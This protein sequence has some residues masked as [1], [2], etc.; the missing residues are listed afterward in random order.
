[1][2]RVLLAVYTNGHFTELLR[3]ARLLMR[4]PGH[5]PTVY[6]ARAYPQKDRDVAACRAEGIM[7][8]DPLPETPDGDHAG[9]V[10][11][12]AVP[13][14]AAR[15]TRAVRAGLSSLPFPFTAVRAAARQAQQ[16]LAARRVVAGQEPA[17]IFLAEDGVGYET[18]TLIKAGHDR[19]VPSI[20]VPFTVANALEPAEAYFR[21]PAFNVNRFSNRLAAALHPNWV[22]EHRGQKLVRLPAPQLLAKEWWGLAP[23]LPWILH[24]GSADAI[25]VES[26]FMKDYY[27]REGLP[28][29]QLVETGALSDDALAETQKEAGRRR[30]E[31][32]AELGLPHDR[33]LLLC[34]LPPDQ[35]SI[36]GP[37]A[38]FDDY[39]TMVRAWVESMTAMPGWTVVVRL[40]PRMAYDEF[41]Y[42]EE[43]GVR[44]SQRDTATLIPL[45][46]L[47][48]AS[49]SA[50]IR[51]AIAC[52]KPVVNFD[53]YRLKWTD[54]DDALG[55]IRLEDKA[56]FAA[57][58]LRLASDAAYFE[59]VR[60][61]QQ[62]DA[63]RWA[64][65]DGRAAERL[66]QLMASVIEQ[67]PRPSLS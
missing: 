21:D 40:H 22:F 13:P 67:A 41:R 2:R 30:A 47:Y 9:L 63:P 31:L 29:R 35:F 8:V 14:P 66:L 24:S 51:W 50:T 26:R 25:A 49:V 28:A 38:D 20:I 6:F 36:S 12:P 46:D 58:L 52:G 5:A 23:P 45:C 48:V 61:R 42:I 16:L 4:T 53:V 18:A 57:T 33:R 7:V 54:Y 10:T 43:W 32:C 27:L 55:V 65:L 11:P 3:V 62:A 15:L 60:S 64:H 59:D 39:A 1:M 37:Q 19:G 44:I 56:A 34:A 17:V